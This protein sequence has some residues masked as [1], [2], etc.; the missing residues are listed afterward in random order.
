MTD[1][2][3]AGGFEGWLKKADTRLARVERALGRGRIPLT[4]T[5][6]SR[7]RPARLQPGVRLF[8]TDTNRSIYVNAAQ[9]GYVD[10]AGAA[11]A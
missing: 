4:C 3:A 7:P 11:L 1:L 6:T 9:S 2:A 8:E 10:S 5:S